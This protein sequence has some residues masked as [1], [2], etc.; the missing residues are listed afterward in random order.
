MVWTL[1]PKPDAGSVVQPKTPAF[2][3]PSRD[4]QPLPPPDALHPLGIDP[5]TVGPQQRGNAPIAVAAISTGQPDDRRGQNRFIVPDQV[6][7]AL[8]RTRLADQAAGPP[9]RERQTLLQIHYALT[10]AFRA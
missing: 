4:F 8:G 6:R 1:R 3:L 9:F 10:S 5:P 7:L 2:R